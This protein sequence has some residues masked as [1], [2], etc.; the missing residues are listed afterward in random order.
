MANGRRVSERGGEGIGGTGG[1]S[2]RTVIKGA[3]A[4]LAVAAASSAVT[5]T[6]A[7]AAN[8]KLVVTTMPGPR[9]EMALKASA[10]AYMEKNKDVEIEVLVSPMPNTISAS[11]PA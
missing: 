3:A 4:G 1:V 10:K 6:G 2:R 7:I 8:K 5:W 9:W 11:A